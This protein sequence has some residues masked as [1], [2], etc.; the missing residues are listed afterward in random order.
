M[1]V[2]AVCC[3]TRSGSTFL[4]SLLES[5]GLGKPAEYLNHDEKTGFPHWRKVFGLPESVSTTDYLD[6]IIAGRQQNGIFGIKTVR[7]A[8]HKAVAKHAPTVAVFLRRRDTLRQAISLYRAE[9]SGAFVEANGF[10]R[11]VPFCEASILKAQNRILAA[12]SRWADYLG[13]LAEM[14]RNVFYE[15][16]VADPM[17]S[18]LK[19]RDFLGST[20]PITEVEADTDIMSD[21]ITDEWERRLVSR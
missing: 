21:E 15:D 17:G 3:T 19:I 6:T 12:N 10:H 1:T 18:V 13:G 9:T 5:A 11:A 4:C 7:T 20:L 2:Y 14:P 8:M 16:V